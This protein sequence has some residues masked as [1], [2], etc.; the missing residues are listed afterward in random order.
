MISRCCCTSRN[1]HHQPFAAGQFAG[2]GHG[3]VD[4][5]VGADPDSLFAS[6]LRID[7]L[8]ASG[9]AGYA[10]PPDNPFADGAEGRPEIFA[11]GVR[12]PWRISFDRD[13]GALWVGD[14]G[15]GTWEEVDLVERGGNYGWR[16]Y[17]G[18]REYR[19]PGNLPATD[20]EAPIVDYGRSIGASVS[21]GYVYRIV[22]WRADEMSPADSTLRPVA[23][24]G[25]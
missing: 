9:G 4:V 5:A 17:E 13:T 25:G 11:I 10:I 14:V 18:N 3:L 1:P 7:P 2:R 12:N 15:Q 23:E 8:G 22:Q 6:L 16:Y 21:G 20:F 24:G 19:N